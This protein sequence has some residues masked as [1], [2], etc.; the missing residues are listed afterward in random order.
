[1]VAAPP[2]LH[3]KSTRQPEFGQR[4]ALVTNRAERPVAR[5]LPRQRGRW[6]IGGK[7]PMQMLRTPRRHTLH[8]TEAGLATDAS[9]S[10]RPMAQATPSARGTSSP[11]MGPGRHKSKCAKAI[12][13]INH[14]RLHCDRRDKSASRMRA[15]SPSKAGGTRASKERGTGSPSYIKK[16]WTRKPPSI[17]PHWT[18]GALGRTPPPPS[19]RHWRSSPQPP[20]PE[21]SYRVGPCRSAYKRARR[22]TIAQLPPARGI[23]PPHT[24]G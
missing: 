18:D 16:P 19:S 5:C 23:S 8:A 17:R 20:A 9:T 22:K 10:N 24:D 21:V 14:T 12:N 11:S 6:G 4:R 3:D 15:D 13:F 1:M 2:C 7:P